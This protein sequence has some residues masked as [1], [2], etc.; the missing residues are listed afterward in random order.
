MRGQY[1]GQLE[2]FCTSHIRHLIKRISAAAVTAG[3]SA[4]TTWR[5][6]AAFAVALLPKGNPLSPDSLAPFRIAASARLRYCLTENFGA[7]TISTLFGF[8]SGIHFCQGT[9]VVST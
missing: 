9:A 4:S 3:P 8:S 7:R 2:A 5:D 1:G 6:L